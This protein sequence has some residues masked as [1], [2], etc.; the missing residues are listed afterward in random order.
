MCLAL[1]G[2][3]LA[4]GRIGA[5][6]GGYRKSGHVLRLADGSATFLDVEFLPLEC[7]TLRL[8][9]NPAPTNAP[10]IVVEFDETLADIDAR[11]EFT[12]ETPFYR[13][14]FDRGLRRCRRQ[15]V[16][17]IAVCGMMAMGLGGLV[18]NGER[19]P[20]HLFSFVFGVFVALLMYGKRLTREWYRNWVRA[21]VRQHVRASEGVYPRRVHV[22]LRSG[23]LVM[24]WPDYE[25]R[26][27][28]KYIWLV[29]HTATHVQIITNGKTGVAIPLRAFP[30]PTDAEAF[31]ADAN[32]RMSQA[33]ESARQ[34]LI[35]FLADTSAV[36]PS[37]KYALRGVI[38]EQCP[39]CGRVL[40]Q[41]ELRET[42][43]IQA[44]KK[45]RRARSFRVVW[46]WTRRQ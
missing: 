30:R 34:R 1:Q 42:L 43:S 12:Y 19:V 33:G 8:V 28:W 16:G 27:G 26:V 18:L 4:L 15:T 40:D 39:E 3:A 24:A 36:C 20:A 2:A 11:S 32:S 9:S 21:S 35:R 22:T 14:S 44:A 6:I 13:R 17:W 31:S 7:V 37:C 23:G 10:D 41:S 46:P 25:L 29:T 45:S 5:S 38:L